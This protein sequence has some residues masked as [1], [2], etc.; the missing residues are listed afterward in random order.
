MGVECLMYPQRLINAVQ[1]NWRIIIPKSTHLSA[2]RW[3]KERFALVKSGLRLVLARHNKRST[4]ILLRCRDLAGNIFFLLI[5]CCLFHY[6]TP[7]LTFPLQGGRDLY[8][9]FSHNPS[10]IRWLGSQGGE[11]TV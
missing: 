3:Q 7:I 6:Y 9:A 10:N 4:S 8:R 1:L 11:E 2:S 5:C